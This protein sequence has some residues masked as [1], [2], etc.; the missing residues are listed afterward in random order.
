MNA[1]LS[2]F[3]QLPSSELLSR[4]QER[5]PLIQAALAPF[6]G[7]I[8]ISEMMHPAHCLLSEL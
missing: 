2:K 7:C 3:N 6:S 1:R 5:T 8:R 4:F